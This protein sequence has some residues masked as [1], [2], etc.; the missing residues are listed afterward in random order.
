MIDATTLSKVLRL[1]MSKGYV[2]AD[3]KVYHFSIHSDDEYVVDEYTTK[4]TY[5][6]DLKKGTVTEKDTVYYGP[7][8]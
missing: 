5:S 1:V 3:A 6:V 7:N 4:K 2:I 8:G